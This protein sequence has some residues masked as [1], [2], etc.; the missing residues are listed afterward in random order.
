MS[1]KNQANRKDA[2]EVKVTLRRSLLGTPEKHRKVARALGLGKRNRSVVQYDTPT[3]RGMINKISYLLD[4]Q[5][6]GQGEAV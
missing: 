6:V 4:I 3:I 2:K 1:T 5:E